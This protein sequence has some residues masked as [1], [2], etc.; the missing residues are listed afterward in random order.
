MASQQVN[1][2]LVKLSIVSPF[3]A[4][5]NIERVNSESSLQENWESLLGREGQ[6]YATIL[7]E[8]NIPISKFLEKKELKKFLY[9]KRKSE[10][11]DTAE[12]NA[13]I[14]A[15]FV[16]DKLKNMPDEE[17]IRKENFEAQK[18]LDSL[19]SQFRSVHTVN[20]KDII[21]VFV[22]FQEFID[23]H[24]VH[25]QDYVPLLLRLLPKVEGDK[26]KKLITQR[27]GQTSS[28][29]TLRTV[30]I[31][32]INTKTMR[33]HRTELRNTRIEYDQVQQEFERYFFSKA[34][35]V[36]FT[37]SEALHEFLIIVS[38]VNPREAE[39]LKRIIIQA[40]K[41]K[42]EDEEIGYIE[43]LEEYHD[44]QVDDDHY[45]LRKKSTHEH[46]KSLGKRKRDEDTSEDDRQ[47]LPSPKPKVC[48]KCGDPNH[49]QKNCIKQENG[50]T[51][52][53]NKYKPNE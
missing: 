42:G 19:A 7:G 41:S 12:Q 20:I 13:L 31:E 52:I 49:I 37:P 25:A 33:D 2:V 15:I 43:V 3:K 28:W 27:N 22:K 29:N 1:N 26:L 14:G 10:D 46:E 9:K 39:K 36:G 21:D 8:K 32:A 5:S 6:T 38:K 18:R 30:I 48:W 45:Y 44:A 24:M 4:S 35:I 40:K 50:S 17:S 53:R 47:P 11:E 51:I 34:E 16:L 23:N